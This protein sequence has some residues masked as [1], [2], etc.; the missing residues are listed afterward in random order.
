[1][2]PP[3]VVAQEGVRLQIHLNFKKLRKFVVGLAFVLIN[4]S[5]PIVALREVGG[6]NK[7]TFRVMG[8]VTPPWSDALS[9]K[10]PDR[11]PCR[12]D[13]A[14]ARRGPSFFF[15]LTTRQKNPTTTQPTITPTPP[16]ISW[17]GVMVV[18]VGG[19]Q[20]RRKKSPTN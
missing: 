8:T 1:M 4:V 11:V 13:H 17:E 15:I 12:A 18:G 16:K 10:G 6:T 5:P 7:V 2:S 20:S 9:P 3:V 14:A 19:R